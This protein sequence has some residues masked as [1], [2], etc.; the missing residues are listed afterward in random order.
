SF[1]TRRSSDLLPHQLQEILPQG[2]LWLPHYIVGLELLHRVAVAAA[3]FQ[4][5]PRD[6]K[7]GRK[8]PPEIDLLPDRRHLG[9]RVEHVSDAVTLQD[10][11]MD[12]GE[13]LRIA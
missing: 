9:P 8:R 7:A 5:R 2:R 13:Q 10:L 1:P 6:C 3:R 11:A 4:Q 12:T